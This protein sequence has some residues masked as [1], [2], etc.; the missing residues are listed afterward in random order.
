MAILSEHPD[1]ASPNLRKMAKTAES[2]PENC[3]HVRGVCCAHQSHRVVEIREKEC[4]GDIHAIAVS[5]ANGELQ[6]KCQ[7]V[8]RQLIDRDLVFCRG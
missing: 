7:V 3:A 6:S 1:S 8:L 5:L 2:V 4:I